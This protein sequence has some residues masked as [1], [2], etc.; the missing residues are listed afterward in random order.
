METTETQRVCPV[1]YAGV[2]EHRYRRRLQNPEKILSPFVSPGMKVL[3][4]GCGPGYFTLALSAL[5]GK[6]GTVIAADLQEEMLDIIGQKT[7]AG[8]GSD[9]IRL[10]LCNAESIGITDTLDFVLCFYMVHEVPDRT[11]LLNEIA[12]NLLPGGILF[13]VEPKFHVSKKAFRQLMTDVENAGFSIEGKPSV[14]FSRALVCVKKYDPAFSVCK[15]NNYPGG[16]L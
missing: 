1:K 10:H 5:V 6:E 14:F 16:K 11:A 7:A 3:D 2:L 4:V 8:Q 12:T 13:I 9:N 15:E